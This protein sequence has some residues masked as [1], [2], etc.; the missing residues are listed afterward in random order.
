M[1]LL[2][3]TEMRRGIEIVDIMNDLDTKKEK[4]NVDGVDE[5]EKKEIIKKLVDEGGKVIDEKK[6]HGHS[7]DRKKQKEWLNK[8]TDEIN[9]ANRGIFND[10]YSDA[11]MDPESGSKMHKWFSAWH[12][13]IV[14][15]KG[16]LNKTVTLNGRIN[17]LFFQ[18]IKGKAIPQLKNLESIIDYIY[19]DDKNQQVVKDA[20][21]EK[22]VYYYTLF[23]KY[24][25]L[26]FEDEFK[27]LLYYHNRPV[28]EKATPFHLEEP[29]RIIFKKIYI[30]RGF[31]AD[32][33]NVFRTVLFI[34]SK[35]KNWTETVYRR[36][37]GM[38]R[39]ALN[40][41]FTQL[42]PK[43]YSILLFIFK[44]NI[45]LN[46]KR[47]SSYLNVDE[48]EEVDYIP[49]DKSGIDYFLPQITPTG[50]KKKEAGKNTE[51]YFYD[52]DEDDLKSL[53]LDEEII[54]GVKIMQEVDRQKI[55]DGQKDDFLLKYCSEDDRILH[56]FIFLKEFELEYSFILTSHK[57]DIKPVFDK[58]KR[59]DYRAEMNDFYT[60]LTKIY[61]GF[62]G[63]FEI[64][65]MMDDYNSDELMDEYEKYNRITS[66]EGKKD[67]IAIELNKE[68]LK[69]FIE[70]KQY[71]NK[72]I[73][74]YNGI[75]QII[76]NPEEELYFDKEVE[77]D[78]KI[79]GLKVIDA[80][81]TINL[82]ISVFIFRLEEGGDLS[83]IDTVINS[84]EVPDGDGEESFLDEI[85]EAID[86]EKNK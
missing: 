5:Q 59:V 37:I 6:K 10:E 40:L 13:I 9:K 83:G 61:E 54:E 78:K 39:S 41:L 4:L 48:A 69:Y 34:I 15:I 28:T 21:D 50:I 2:Y 47:I 16:L 3:L 76:N 80:V 55:I 58:D 70:L 68:I 77:G 18:F 74:D 1:S 26:F 63:Y 27:A 22:E 81:K 65:K 71:F 42:L 7:F 60:S 14:H 51:K 52:L 85:V 82:Y 11:G 25:E 12:Y 33:L 64:I 53:D 32:S 24:S 49:D 66:A 44:E 86:Y 35:K 23:L 43:F 84:V 8:I 72:F 17:D 79:H 19:K 38:V 36:E 67:K 45:S 20:L 73:D 29:L 57:I 30:L 62:Q 75:R 56:I 46:S 31:D